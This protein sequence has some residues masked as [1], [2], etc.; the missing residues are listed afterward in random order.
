MIDCCDVYDVLVGE[1]CVCVVACLHVV[2]GRVVHIWYVV[3]RQS[4]VSIR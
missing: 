2:D 1:G 4:V 3:C